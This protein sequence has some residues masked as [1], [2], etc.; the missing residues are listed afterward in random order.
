MITLHRRAHSFASALSC[1]R[2]LSLSVSLSVSLSRSSTLSFSLYYLFCVAL[3]Y[4]DAIPYQQAEPEACGAVKVFEPDFGGRR[5]LKGWEWRAAVCQQVQRYCSDTPSKPRISMFQLMGKSIYQIYQLYQLYQ[6][7]Q[8]YQDYQVYSI[9]SN[10]TNIDKYV[11]PLYF[12]CSSSLLL[13]L[14]CMNVR[15]R[16]RARMCVCVCVCLYAWQVHLLMCS[17]RSRLPAWSPH[18]RHWR[19]TGQDSFEQAGAQSALLSD[20]VRRNIKRT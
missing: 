3:K 4:A 6:L 15:A 10:F 1:S 14:F 12:L 8:D 9:K 20:N 17:A 5:G 16:A 2:I 7:Y 19:Q 18:G 13:S 11:Y